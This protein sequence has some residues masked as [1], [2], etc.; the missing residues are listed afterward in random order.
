MKRI[1]LAS[2]AALGLAGTASAADLAVKAPPLVPVFTWS[3]CYL[4]ANAGWIGGNDAYTLQ[5][6][7]LWG[8]VP[9]FTP[10]VR[11]EVYHSYKQNDSSG[12]AGGQFGC[13][14]QWGALV[15]GG[16]WDFNWSGLKENNGFIFPAT[17]DW[18][19]RFEFTH[20]QL[21]WFSTARA[22]LGWA[23]WD[24]VLVYGTGGLV[25]GA[26]D[27]FT[28]VDL[29][30]GFNDDHFGDFRQKRIGWTAGGGVEWAFTNN[31]TVKAEFLYLDFS[32]FNYISPNTTT[33]AA[34]ATTCR[35]GVSPSCYWNTDI[36]ANEYVARVGV[37]YLFHLGP[38]AAPLVAAY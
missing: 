11:N 4:G 16:E 33:P 9:G 25:V 15:L 31:W 23:I 34:G 5:P 8:T 37:N 35:T 30:P 32:S 1:L 12:T 7:G 29:R 14:W 6:A 21:D 20:K 17:L 2:V 3:G 24:R 38:A 26:L 18:P 27:S 28:N 22:R 13:Q 36:R 19:Q 10:A